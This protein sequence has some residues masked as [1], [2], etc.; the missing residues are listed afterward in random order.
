MPVVPHRPEP[1]VDLQPGSDQPGVPAHRPFGR[2]RGATAHQDNCG[3]V[4]VNRHRGTGSMPI[5][6]EQL[7]EP[8]CTRGERALLRRVPGVGHRVHHAQEWRQIVLDVCRDHARDGR[9]RLDSI[10]P[11][12]ERSQS[13]HRL[14]P[15]VGQEELQFLAAVQGIERHHDRSGLPD[16][17]FRDDELWAVRE[18]Q[19]QAVARHDPL[20]AQGSGKGITQ[21]GECF[22]RHAAPLE[23][24]GTPLS[25]RPSAHAV[26]GGAGWSGHC[27]A[28]SAT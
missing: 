10:H 27:R 19:R 6:L 7:P 14:S 16:A 25:W 5:R 1:G 23:E 18:Q 17:Q 21:L 8:Q 22:I 12:G 20:V 3:V 13:D 2:A 24:E 4:R 15:A 11:L 26:A 28:V 9:L